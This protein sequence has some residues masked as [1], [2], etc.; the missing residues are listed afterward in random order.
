[1]KPKPSFILILLAAVIV[2]VA[3]VFYASRPP[4]KKSAPS[5]V[6]PA[7][8]RAASPPPV[9]GA[10]VA[11]QTASAPEILAV[12]KSA[13]VSPAPKKFTDGLLG[14]SCGGEPRK[15]FMREPH[16]F[17]VNFTQ[18]IEHRLAVA[19]FCFL[20]PPLFPSLSA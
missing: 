9:S 11:A 15:F 7:V 10:T 12:E 19:H 8:A 4:V 5:A 13:D 18:S 14:N 16:A 3:C 6:V 1:M 17:C 20:R 2:A